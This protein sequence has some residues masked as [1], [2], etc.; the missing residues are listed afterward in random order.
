V[1]PLRLEKSS[2][3]Q[4]KTLRMDTVITLRDSAATQVCMTGSCLQGTILTT[5]DQIVQRLGHPSYGPD[6]TEGDKVSAEW[7]LQ[8]PNGV[9]ASLYD[10][11][12]YGVTPK[13]R[14]LWHIGGC[15]PEVVKLVTK[16]FGPE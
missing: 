6:D 3:L 10:W 14:Y 12:E 2:S 7:I 1:R 15:T 8:F 5:Y 4:G 13:D 16:L 11:K 9:L